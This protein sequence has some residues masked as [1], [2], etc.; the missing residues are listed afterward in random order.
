MNQK[1]WNQWV[2]H[3]LKELTYTSPVDG[4][5]RFYILSKL[6]E[7]EILLR[8]RPSHNLAI[9]GTR[10]PT[11][12]STEW[13]THHLFPTLPEDIQII[14]GLALGIDA[15]LH[16]LC[17]LNHHP[18]LAILGSGFY[19]PYPKAHLSL[20]EALVETGNS[21][22][23]PFTPDT[24]PRRY[25]FLQRNRWIAEW[26]KATLIIEAPQ[27][28]GC[29]NTAKWAREFDRDVYACCAHPSDTRFQ[30]N[31]NLI[32]RGWAQPFI[33][34]SDLQQTWWNY[35]FTLPER[36]SSDLSVENDS[37]PPSLPIA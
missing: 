4:T 21:V 1:H 15:L 24:P 6:S 10:H 12:K 27:S 2:N 26:S 37:S 22:I 13:V 5:H 32:A 28:S 16:Q 19:H 25:Q 35:D 23:S 30:G 11:Y 7:N 8:L 18:T 17:V 14:S 34:P 33:Y 9:V 29:L 31:L 20:L 36:F 3:N